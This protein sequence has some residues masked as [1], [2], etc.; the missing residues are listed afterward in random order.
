MSEATPTQRSAAP[1]PR[2]LGAA[3]LAALALALGFY[4]LPMPWPANRFDDGIVCVA[5][6]RILA[7]E[8]PYIDFSVLYTPG[9][10]YVVAAAFRVFGDSYATL[11]GVGVVTRALQAWAVWHVARRLGAGPLRSSVA[12][13]AGLAFSYP[14]PSVALALATILYAARAVR[15]A[16]VATAALAGAAAG[17]TAWFRQD[18]GF[19]AA[20]AAGAVVWTRADGPWTR[21]LARAA[22][23]GVCAAATLGVL[24]AP[25]L[26]RDPLEV[27]TQLVVHPAAT[28][29]YRSLG[30]VGEALRGFAPSQSL[31]AALLVAAVLL[32]VAVVAARDRA[33]RLFD[34]TTDLPLLVGTA[35]LAA[36]ALRYWFVRPDHHHFVPAGLLAGAASG[37]A[38]AAPPFRV[39]PTLAWTV[40]SAAAVFP[41][42]REH[43]GARAAHRFGRRSADVVE[44]VRWFPEASRLH[45]PS[46]EAEDYARL[47]QRV[48]ELAAPGEPIFSAAARH[49]FVHDQ[50]LL[51]YWLSGRPAVLHGDHFDPGV[52]TRE[53]VQRRMVA[54]LERHRVRVVVRRNA[55]SGEAPAVAPGATL[56]DEHLAQRYAPTESI[57]RYEIWIRRE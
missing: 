31:I 57:G 17:V 37:I 12:A 36:W 21:R 28:L 32:G 33:A 27:W 40:L 39:R 14:Y 24:L 16:T 42:F 50:D 10:N 41:W 49:D 35:V 20:L 15:G 4:A 55:K 26:L 19:A 18:F 2:A 54:D 48:R 43:A 8:I 34:R 5:A 9:Q 23:C 52:T 13:M 29:P 44:M 56:L 25:A 22:V 3:S 1:A 46:S 45:L 11:H 51:L 30:T 53:D 47:V 6:R 38:F 7:G